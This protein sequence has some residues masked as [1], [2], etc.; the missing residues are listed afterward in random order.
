M[1]KVFQA[2]NLRQFNS[3]IPKISFAL[4]SMVRCKSQAGFG[5]AVVSDIG[6]VQ[7]ETS[8]RLPNLSP[9]ALFIE[10]LSLVPPARQLVLI[11]LSS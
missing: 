7:V 3:S 2:C 9:F 4:M 6:L 8:S 11:A 10:T 1:N 5:V